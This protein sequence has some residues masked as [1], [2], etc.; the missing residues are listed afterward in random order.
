M[1]VCLNDQVHKKKDMNQVLNDLTKTRERL[2]NYQ[3]YTNNLKAT[4]QRNYNELKL[5]NM[6]LKYEINQL[7]NTDEQIQIKELKGEIANKIKIIG[8][9]KKSLE[10]L[11]CAGSVDIEE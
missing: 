5:E 6:Q 9:L 7:K 3:N 4:F 2:Y 1:D 8:E 10:A 11:G